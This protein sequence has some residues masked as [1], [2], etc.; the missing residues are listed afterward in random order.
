MSWAEHRS[1]IDIE[2]ADCYYQIEELENKIKI[3]KARKQNEKLNTPIKIKW[4]E[5]ARGF[6]CPT[7]HTGVEYKI[8]RCQFCGQMLIEPN[9]SDSEFKSID[10]CLKQGKLPPLNLKSKGTKGIHVHKNGLT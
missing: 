6:Y 10:K 4:S 9:N 1:Q 5:T 3:L 8:Q 2:I 7:C